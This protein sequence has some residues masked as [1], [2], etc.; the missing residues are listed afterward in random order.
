MAGGGGGAVPLK[1]LRPGFA[2]LIGT[3]AAAAVVA[4]AVAA[5]A[6]VKQVFVVADDRL[7]MGGVEAKWKPSWPRLLTT[8]SFV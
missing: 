2:W 1:R 3:G 5:T 8:W 4:V 6:G 7:F